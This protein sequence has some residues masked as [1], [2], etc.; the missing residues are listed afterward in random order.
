MAALTICNCILKVK[1][2]N[3]NPYGTVSGTLTSGNAE[4]SFY[5]RKSQ[6]NSSDAAYISKTQ[7]SQA[8]PGVV[9][10]DLLY[11]AVPTPA[12]VPTVTYTSGAVAGSE[13]VTVVGTAITIQIASGV[14]T[15]TQIQTAFNKVLA[16]TSLAYCIMSGTAGNTQTAVAAT[17]FSSEYCYLPLSETTTNN[18]QGI[19][20]LIWN[21]GSN[22][23][24]VIFDP[25]KI[26][27]QS[28]QDLSSVLTVSRG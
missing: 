20:Q 4:L 13:V 7:R 22:Y 23:G 11:I 27:A 25:L 6:V 24:S 19:F 21:D 26:P 1:D 2:Q 8:Q 17:S 9:V 10:Q 15:A 16:A 28:F 14:S 12:A 3:G 5:T 18:Q